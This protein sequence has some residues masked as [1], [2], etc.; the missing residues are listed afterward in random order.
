MKEFIQAKN[1]KL[2]KEKVDE[3]KVDRFIEC[4]NKAIAKADPEETDGNTY[5]LNDGLDKIPTL[6][7]AEFQTAANKAKK[8]GWKLTQADDN[9]QSTTYTMIKL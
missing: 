7:D 2:P 8:A 9:Y 5:Y 6:N 3:K 1:A 4:F